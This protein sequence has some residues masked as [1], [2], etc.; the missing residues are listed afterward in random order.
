MT[1]N[2]TAR[3]IY[4]YYISRGLPPNVAAGFVG[5]F[6]V[7]SGNFS[8]EVITGKK[9]GDNGTAYYMQQLRGDR[10]SN[11]YRFAESNGLSTTDPMAQAAFTLEEINPHSPFADSIT[12]K[13]MDKIMKSATPADAANA[14][15][16]H[17]ERASSNPKLNHIDKRQ[18]YASLISETINGEPASMSDAGV[19]PNEQTYGQVDA[20]PS[21]ATPHNK[22]NNRNNYEDNS[23]NNYEDDSPTAG[24]ALMMAG[25]MLMGEDAPAPLSGGGRSQN[26]YDGVQDSLETPL[27]RAS[28]PRV[29]SA[30]DGASDGYAPSFLESGPSD[31]LPV[32]KDEAI[33]SS[34]QTQFGLRARHENVNL[35]GLRP[36]VR[37]AA[38]RMANRLGMDIY[39]N[40]GYR[41]QKRQDQIRARGNPNRVTVAKKS[42][43]TSG[44][45]FDKYIEP[46]TSPAELARRVEA[47]IQEGFTGFGWYPNKQ[48]GGHLH[49]D[50]RD[51]V[52][53]SFSASRQWGGWTSLPPEVIEVLMRR[54]YKPGRPASE[55]FRGNF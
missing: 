1:P 5:N 42:H 50:F 37:D 24:D 22:H 34:D 29:S 25:L 13:N 17:Y 33:V 16:K 53:N 49:L 40:S 54:G 35:E 55:I 23:R 31:P 14:I 41:S 48:G 44:N 39:A 20:T 43:H 47:G 21:W 12:V 10:R 4:Q 45:A 11:F 38:N 18:T 26:F 28:E 51:S 36:E 46:K 8:P 52:P 19:L 30:P 9:R 27:Y 3:Q 2:E 32:G 7:E 6:A 15:M